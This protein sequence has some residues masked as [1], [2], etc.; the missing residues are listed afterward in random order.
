MKKLLLVFLLLAMIKGQ[1]QEISPNLL[2]SSGDFF[3]QGNYSLSWSLGEIA[4]ETFITNNAI[5]TQ[6]FQQTNLSTSSIRIADVEDES[7]QIYPNP[8]SDQLFISIQ[9]ELH[10]DLSLEI[11]DL[12]GV[13]KVTQ[14][15]DKKISITEINTSNLETGTYIVIVWSEENKVKFTRLLHKID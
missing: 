8:A 13:K 7:M 10:E 3:T 2:T 5:L 4:I 9:S 6:G 1:S 11:I 12:L 15:I 14:F